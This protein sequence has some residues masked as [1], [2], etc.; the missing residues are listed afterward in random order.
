MLLLVRQTAVTEDS[1]KDLGVWGTLDRPPRSVEQIGSFKGGSRA[2][3]G[4][5]CSKS[6]EPR[7]ANHFLGGLVL[8]ELEISE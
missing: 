6:T 2:H 5:V 4:C 7:V 8:K 1:W 3:I